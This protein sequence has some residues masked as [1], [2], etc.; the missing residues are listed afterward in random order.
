MIELLTPFAGECI[1]LL[2]PEH[3]QY[4][5]S[6]M[7]TPADNVNWLRLKETNPERSRPQ[8]V[9][10]TYAPAVDGEVLLQHPDGRITHHPAVAGKATLTN[11]LIGATY[12]WQIS[13]AGERSET[14]TFQ[15][16]ATPPRLLLVDGISNVRD[17]GGF[18]TK[19]GRRVRQGLLYRTSE[20]D[21]HVEITEAG[22]EAL[23]ALG[24]R[25]DLDIRG[26]N[27]EHRAPALDTDK[28]EWINIPLVAYEKIFEDDRHIAAYGKAYALLAEA[29]RYPM[30]V[31]CWGGIDRTGCWLFILGGM[32]GVEPEQ[33]YLD[34][35]FSSFSRWGKR[36][37]YSE[38]FSAFSERL[39]AYGSNVEQ[40]CR[41][42][43]LAAGVSEAQM[44][45]IKDM[46]L[47]D[48]E[49]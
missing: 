16:A 44:A 25:T 42:F 41:S 32:L 9:T 35:E 15:T 1:T 13:A 4:I 7:N 34:Y 49:A 27:D 30:I 45:R 10:L 28:V 2:C 5:I 23:Y 26:C 20:M 3:L 39:M 43:M 29:D 47:E 37:R 31:H 11:L 19:D 40:A 18:T 21:T 17:F 38:Q 33:L 46:L 24:I 48:C 8:P 14:R 12:A 36:S 6:P 22:K